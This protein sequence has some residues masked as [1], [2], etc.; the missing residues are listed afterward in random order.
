MPTAR[1]QNLF[2]FILLTISLVLAWMLGHTEDDAFITFR[3]SKHLANGLGPVWNA[4]DQPPVEGFSNFLWMLLMV[5]PHWLGIEVVG[6]SHVLGLLF[7]GVNLWTSWKVIALLITSP[8]LR[9]TAIAAIGLNYTLLGYATSGLETSMNGAMVTL[10]CW[11]LIKLLL[12]EEP[13]SFKRLLGISL[14]TG[15]LFWSRHDNA[16]FIGLALSFVFMKT[17]RSGGYSYK[18]L[19]ALFGPAF[20]LFVGLM[21]WRISFYGYFLPNTFLVKGGGFNFSEGG[22]FVLAAFGVYGFF[23][24]VFFQLARRILPRVKRN[25]SLNFLMWAC[26]LWLAY[27]VFIGGDYMEFRMLVPILPLSI[28]FLSGDMEFSLQR[29]KVSAALVASLILFSGFHAYAHGRLYQLQFITPI[30]RALSA[31]APPYL[32]LVEQAKEIDITFDKINQ[33]PLLFATGNCGAYGYY[34]DDIDWIDLYG[35]NDYWIARNGHYRSFGPGHSKIA[36]FAHLL[37]RGTHLVSVAC[38]HKTAPIFLE[39]YKNSDAM[40]DAVLGDYKL[41]EGDFPVRVLE[42]PLKNNFILLCLYIHS[43]PDIEALII[44]GNFPPPKELKFY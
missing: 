38:F 28:I 16:F 25:A 2:F 33:P 43:H 37:D 21:L 29:T 42:I 39:P 11:G 17:Y 23:L 44:R 7:W 6:F 19:F 15:I 26:L 20:A 14:W 10:L 18:S 36:P 1:Q 12:A 3:Y 40:F 5:I 34:N 30:H 31:E 9:L 27:L 35:L 41:V 8:F 32:G 22:F 4:T 24:P 13:P